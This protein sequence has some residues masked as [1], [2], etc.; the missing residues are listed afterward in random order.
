MA[1][2]ER[3]STGHERKAR[4]LLLKEER[5]L[6]CSGCCWHELNSQNLRIRRTLYAE[7]TVYFYRGG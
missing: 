2:G 7:L 6:Q 5:F 1:K 3:C 4:A